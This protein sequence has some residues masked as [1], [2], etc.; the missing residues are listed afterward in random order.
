[1]SQI[2]TAKFVLAGA[3]TLA[4]MTAGPAVAQNVIKLGAVIDQTGGSTS[5]HYVQAVELA[6]KQMNEAL[7]QAKSKVRFEWVFGDSKSN[8][9]FA[10]GEA[11]KLINESGVKALVA[12]SSGVI[13][14]INRLNYDPD[15][16]AKAKV[17][18]TCFQCSSSFINDPKVE[19]K[20]PSVQAAERDVDNW[21]NRVFY[22]AKY[23]AWALV[24]IVLNRVKKGNAPIKIAVFADGGHRALAT[25]IPKIVPTFHKGPFTIKTVYT[26]GRDKLAEEWP[27]VI[28]DKDEAG[29]TDGPP[30]VAIVAMLPDAAAAAVKI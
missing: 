9:P 10:Q 6:A 28:D 13:V 15:T 20:D 22:S 19:E 4:V 12:D 3:M 11:L 18:I 30:D 25:D 7:A 23:E 17:A 1:M 27:K 8:P 16:K 21:V 5:P 14:A 24:Q 29:K 26:A 2:H